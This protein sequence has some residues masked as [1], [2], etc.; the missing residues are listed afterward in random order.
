MEN[1]ETYLKAEKLEDCMGE[2]GGKNTFLTV[3][4][5]R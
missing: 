1:G 5:I 3:M 4:S 2:L